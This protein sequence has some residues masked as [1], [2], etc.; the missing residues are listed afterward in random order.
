LK[1]GH[2]EIQDDQIDRVLLYHGKRFLAVT[3]KINDIEGFQNHVERFAGACIIV[4]DQY[5]VSRL[6]AFLLKII[7]V[8]QC[9]EASK[10]PEYCSKFYTT[11]S[12]AEPD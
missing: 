8:D 11:T 4:Y 7:S 1:T 12:L 9:L 3:G 10:L 5:P 2:L 6:H